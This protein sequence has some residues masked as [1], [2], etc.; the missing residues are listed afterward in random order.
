MAITT[1]LLILQNKAV[2]QDQ[3]A[4]AN[5]VAMTGMSMFKTVGPVGVGALF[6]WSEKRQDASF[7]PGNH[8][9]FFVL[10]VIE[11]IGVLLTFKPF[12]VVR[13]VSV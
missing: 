2:E 5:G 3:R 1:G 13:Q 6:S 4:A 10:N 7:L 11:G 8:M 12:L 9:V